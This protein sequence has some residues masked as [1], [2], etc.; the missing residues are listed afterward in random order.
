MQNPYGIRPTGLN[1]AAGHLH[2]QNL[3]VDQ[4]FIRPLKWWS[5]RGGFIRYRALLTARLGNGSQ[6][7][8][9]AQTGTGRKP[10][11]GDSPG[12]PKGE[13]TMKRKIIIGTCALLGAGLIYIVAALG[14]SPG[15]KVLTADDSVRFE[16]TV[17]E[18]PGTNLKPFPPA[19]ADH[20]AEHQLLK[21]ASVAEATVSEITPE[22]PEKPTPSATPKASANA[23]VKVTAKN[24]AKTTQKTASTPAST[25]KPGTATS[26]VTTPPANSEGL[27]GKVIITA[28]KYLGVP[29]VW[30]APHLPDLTARDSSSM[31]TPRTA[32]RCPGRQRNSM[33]RASPFPRPT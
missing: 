30:A 5:L 31:F 9:P 17:H 16:A 18:G 24:T 22:A 32:L 23:T 28:K 4:A 19:V 7:D 11:H 25:P 2:P 21:A 1:H 10:H 29:Y 26:T 12:K 13:Y 27:A 20:Q 3:Q 8:G 15:G 14:S 6:S 33:E